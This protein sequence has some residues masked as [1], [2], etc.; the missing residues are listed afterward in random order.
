MTDASAFASPV[1]EFG[2][3]RSTTDTDLL[4]AGRDRTL[5]NRQY[6]RT[7]HGMH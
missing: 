4:A 1:A 3:Y 5:L 7:V 6:G 2:D